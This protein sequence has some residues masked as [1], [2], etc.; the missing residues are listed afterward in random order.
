MRGHCDNLLAAGGPDPWKGKWGTGEA[1]RPGRQNQRAGWRHKGE[2]TLRS[3][4]GV[5]GA[6]ESRSLRRE[7]NMSEGHVSGLW[8]LFLPLA[9]CVRV[10]GNPSVCLL[11]VNVL[12]F[13][14]SLVCAII[15]NIL[16]NGIL[17]E[18]RF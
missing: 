8:V 2:G 18:V 11:Q 7:K 9:G 1:W 15:V 13:Y 14:Y 4:S 10:G 6:K 17:L 3:P 16:K 12:H 5:T